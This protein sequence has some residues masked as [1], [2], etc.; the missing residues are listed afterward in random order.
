MRDWKEIG[1]FTKQ[2]HHTSQHTTSENTVRDCVEAL[3]DFSCALKCQ[4]FR[5]KKH[6]RRLEKKRLLVFEFLVHVA[7]ARVLAGCFL[8]SVS[9]LVVVLAVACVLVGFSASLIV[10]CGSLLCLFCT[11]LT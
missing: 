3:R 8:Q 9:C 11:V 1:I 2:Q 4:T 7:I 6:M 5:V 10:A